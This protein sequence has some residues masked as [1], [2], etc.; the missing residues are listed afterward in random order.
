MRPAAPRSSQQSSTWPPLAAR[1]ATLNEL[2]LVAVGIF[3]KGDH[4][5][6]ELHRAGRP[7]D[8]DPGLAQRFAGG[9]DVGHADREMAEGAAEIVGLLLVPVMGELDDRAVVLVAI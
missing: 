8:L 5:R 4:R 3:D 1:S 7:R 6:A 2:D 9:I